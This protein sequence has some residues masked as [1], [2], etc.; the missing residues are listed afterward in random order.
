MGIGSRHAPF[1]ARLVRDTSITHPALLTKW[2]AS[3]LRSIPLA[4]INAWA[5]KIGSFSPLCPVART[6]LRAGELSHAGLDRNGGHGRVACP[7]VARGH[8]Y[9]GIPSAGRQAGVGKTRLVEVPTSS[10]WTR[11]TFEPLWHNATEE[12]AETMI[13]HVGASEG[14]F[15]TLATATRRSSA[16]PATSRTTPNCGRTR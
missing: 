16:A 5:L 9:T 2:K 4:S 15:A 13:A 1:P 7:F 3:I 6:P 14:T 12:L 11:P 10:N 8:F